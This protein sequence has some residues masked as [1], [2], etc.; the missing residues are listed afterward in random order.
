MLKCRTVKADDPQA[1]ALNAGSTCFTAKI[2]KAV[3]AAINTRLLVWHAQVYAHDMIA[4]TGQC[5]SHKKHDIVHCIP[6]HLKS[7]SR[8][9]GTAGQGS[10]VVRVVSQ[11]VGLA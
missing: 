6:T 2:G 5:S 7:T 10:L 9:A 1:Q 11:C 8:G 4:A 3:S